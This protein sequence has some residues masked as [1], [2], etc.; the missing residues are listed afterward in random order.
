MHFIEDYPLGSSVFSEHTQVAKLLL[1]HDDIDPNLIDNDGP[2]QL[3][4]DIIDGHEKVVK[5][6]LRR[7]DIN[8]NICFNL[9]NNVI[10]Q[11]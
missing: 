11:M 4:L 6:L 1:N 10:F 9:C 7:E 3:T 2:I 5:L 8:F